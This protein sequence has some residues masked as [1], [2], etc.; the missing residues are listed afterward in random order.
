MQSDDVGAIRLDQESLAAYRAAAI[1]ATRR[2]RRATSAP[3]GSA[4]VRCEARRDLEEGLRL[5]RVNGE[6]ALE[7]S[8]LCALATLA[9]WQGDDA[10]ALVQARCGPGGGRLAH[11]RD[12]EVAAWCR[13]GDAELALGRARAAAEAFVAAQAR[14]SAIASPYRHDASAGLARVALARATRAALAAWSRCWR[15]HRGRRGRPLARGDGVP[16]PRRVDLCRVLARPGGRA[17]ARAASGSAAR[18]GRFRRRPRPSPTPIC[19][20]ASCATSRSTGRSWRRGSRG[21]GRTS[22]GTDRSQAKIAGSRHPS[23]GAV[24]EDNPQR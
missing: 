24:A 6:R 4:S 3:A 14:A 19:A 9:L 8:P 1:G 18:T 15:S 5:L 16:A 11:A 2:S 20:R 10:Q 23:S 13:V 21:A 7:A 22:A 12:Q 17:D